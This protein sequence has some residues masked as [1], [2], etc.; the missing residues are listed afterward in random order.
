MKIGLWAEGA[1]DVAF[2]VAFL[3]RLLKL[4]A[5]AILVR[6]RRGRCI[7]GLK[8][9]LKEVLK[10]FRLCAC[11]HVL[12]CAD[13]H[14]ANPATAAKRARQAIEMASPIPCIVGEA[15]RSL[16][17]WLLADHACLAAALGKLPFD[18]PPDV[19]EIPD[20]KSYLAS[21]YGGRPTAEQ[22]RT[23]AQRMDLHRARNNASSLDRF[24]KDLEAWRK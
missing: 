7:E 6:N 22:L 21:H 15:V 24:L 3:G 9:G 4:P 19:E 11:T 13:R 17:A 16:E 2:Y 5:D 10:E 12:L 14:E 1:D 20:P 23:V 8:A 18:Q